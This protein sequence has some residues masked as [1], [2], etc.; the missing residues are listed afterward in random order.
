MNMPT[1]T[2][3]T[4]VSSSEMI[5][6][7]AD[8]L[9]AEFER[10]AP[11]AGYA[12]VSEL[13]SEDIAKYLRT[14]L[15]LRVCTVLDSADKLA[16]QYRPLKKTLAIP[17][18]MYQLL[19]CIG[20]AYDSD[21]NLEFVPACSITEEDLLG[22]DDMAGLSRL[23]RSFENSGMKVVYGVPKD[24]EGELDFMAMS[25]VDDV[26]LSYKRSHPS[27]GFLASFVRQKKLNEVTGLMSRVI[28]GYESDYKYQLDSLLSAI[29]G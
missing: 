13:T 20:K 17:V 7:M 19:I 23:F 15:W 25:H 3:K 10:M 1:V 22:P 21:F 5:N 2:I 4:E 12:P 11:Y 28:Y 27:Y 6:L 8:K 16:N 24:A 29:N 14:L 26:V 18:L 9:M